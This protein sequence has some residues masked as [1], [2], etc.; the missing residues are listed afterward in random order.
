MF[1]I[2]EKEFG[3]EQTEIRVWVQVLLLIFFQLKV[4]L[5][6]AYK[7]LQCYYQH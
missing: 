2:V 6:T 5:V 1:L 4:T 3:Q 7:C